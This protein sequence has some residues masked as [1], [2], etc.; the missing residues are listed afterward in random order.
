MIRVRHSKTNNVADW[1]DAEFQE[2]VTRG[3]YAEGTTKSDIVLPSDWNA[4]HVVDSS[5]VESLTMMLMGA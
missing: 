4:D 1:T 3:A 5:D 2:Q